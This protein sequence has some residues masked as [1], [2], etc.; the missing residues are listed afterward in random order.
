MY[1]IV[2]QWYCDWRHSVC[3]WCGVSLVCNTTNDDCWG[4]GKHSHQRCWELLMLARNT[5]ASRCTKIADH[6]DHACGLQCKYEAGA[7]HH[8]TFPKLTLMNWPNHHRHQE[9]LIP[10]ESGDIM[11]SDKPENTLRSHL[12]WITVLS[13]LPNIDKVL[14]QVKC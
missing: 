12:Y 3:G 4:S 5:G 7:C 13:C 8:L 6:C 11:T 14:N 10:S 2:W 1:V 9:H